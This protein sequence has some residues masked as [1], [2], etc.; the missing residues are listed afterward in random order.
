LLTENRFH[1]YYDRYRRLRDDSDSFVNKYLAKSRQASVDPSENRSPAANSYAANPA[2]SQGKW[3]FLHD[4]N[5]SFSPKFYIATISLCTIIYFN[6]IPTGT[7]LNQPLYSYHMTQA[8]R[9]RVNGPQDLK[10]ISK[11]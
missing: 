7:G 6:P 2:S 4:F 3:N 1:S 9:N 8:G 5:S 10:T 11:A